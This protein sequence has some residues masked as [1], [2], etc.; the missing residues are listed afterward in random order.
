[1][2][3]YT[4]L[5]R[6]PAMAGTLQDRPAMPF[7][8]SA[9][10]LPPD[11]HTVSILPIRATVYFGEARA[12]LPTNLALRI[13]SGLPDAISTPVPDTVTWYLGDL[14]LYQTHHPVMLPFCYSPAANDLTTCEN[15]G[16]VLRAWCGV[17]PP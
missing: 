3:R 5:C 14:P 8:C 7:I 11:V 9:C 12:A 4:C 1:M 6:V 17:L 16:A 13:R 2:L 15:Y 10:P